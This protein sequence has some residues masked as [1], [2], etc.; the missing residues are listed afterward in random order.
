MDRVEV[1][2]EEN[3]EACTY[4]LSSGKP[5]PLKNADQ[6]RLTKLRTNKLCF[7]SSSRIDRDCHLD[8]AGVDQLKLNL[9]YILCRECRPLVLYLLK[10]W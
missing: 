2:P 4:N 7:E 5:K 1:D 9:T 6:K 10:D 8:L 3:E